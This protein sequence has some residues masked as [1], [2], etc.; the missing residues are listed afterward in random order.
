MFACMKLLRVQ[1]LFLVDG[2][3]FTLVGA[4][5]MVMPSASAAALPPD[6][7]STPHML[8]TRRLLA[9]AY[10]TV[11][12]FLLGFSRG[13]AGPS[14]L[15]LASLLRAVSLFCLVGVNLSQIAGGL[16]KPQSLYGYVGAFSLMA[17]VYL[18]AAMR[19]SKSGEEA[20]K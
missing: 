10:L 6:A 5:V 3:V 1:N 16:W 14:M 19:G 12:L 17:V 8:D 13:P 18:I 15:R 11:G 4:L 20:G 2:L 9:A 7:G